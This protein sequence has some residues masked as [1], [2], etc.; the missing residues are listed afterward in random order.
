MVSVTT[1]KPVLPSHKHIA[2]MDMNKIKTRH[3]TIKTWEQWVQKTKTSKTMGTQDE[4]KQ[5]NG[6]TRRRQAKQK[7][8]HN[9]CWT[10]LQIRHEP[11][12][13]HDWLIVE[14]IKVKITS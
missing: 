1:E 8:Q 5:N 9:M 4:D 7:T 6:Y 12:Y 14:G 13:K 3:D 10:S 2:T 11:S